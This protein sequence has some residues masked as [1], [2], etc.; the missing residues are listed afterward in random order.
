MF[1]AIT[2]QHLSAQELYSIMGSALLNKGLECQYV[3]QSCE[4]LLSS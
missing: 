4:P 2:L 3:I 1:E